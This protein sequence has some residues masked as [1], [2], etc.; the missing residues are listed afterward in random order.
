MKEIILAAIYRLTTTAAVSDADKVSVLKN[1]KLKG[2]KPIKSFS[3]PK[4][5]C[6]LTHKQS[7]NKTQSELVKRGFRISNDDPYWKATSADVTLRYD[8]GSSSRK[9]QLWVLKLNA[10]RSSS[11]KLLNTLYTLLSGMKPKQSKDDDGNDALEIV[12]P[13]SKLIDSVSDIAAAINGSFGTKLRST[14][15]VSKNESGRMFVFPLGA[16]K[17]NIQID[18]DYPSRGKCYIFISLN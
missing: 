4:L 7:W 12:C 8:S 10:P 6:E 16:D 9:P 11:A 5:V 1:L 13:E 3:T 14:I 17:V 18:W 2:W 15:I